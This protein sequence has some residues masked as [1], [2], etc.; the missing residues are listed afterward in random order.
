M[1]IKLTTLLVLVS[2]LGAGCAST[3][4][5][6]YTQNETM[7]VAEVREGVV[8]SLRPVTIAGN[9]TPWVGAGIG[10]VL[11]G[12]AGNAISGHSTGGTIAGAVVGGIAGAVIEN[13]ATK[14]HGDEIT[15]RLDNNQTVAVVQQDGQGIRVGDRV[16]L[17]SEGSRTRV[18]RI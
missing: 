17:V 2:L 8:V 1:E 5:N 14:E 3:S 4:P 15:V 11:G 9:Q 10:A 12:L 16:R 18:Q 6:V 7:R 13:Q